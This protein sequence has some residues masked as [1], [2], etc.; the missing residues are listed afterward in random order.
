[1]G[2][3]HQQ[4]IVAHV[5]TV[6]RQ[7]F[8]VIGRWGDKGHRAAMSEVINQRICGHGPLAAAVNA[9]IRRVNPTG[10]AGTVNQAQLRATLANYIT[11]QLRPTSA[12]IQNQAAGLQLGITRPS[13]ITAQGQVTRP[14]FD[15][16]TVASYR[17]GILAA[18]RGTGIKHRQVGSAQLNLTALA[19]QTVK[20]LVVAIEVDDTA[21]NN[22]FTAGFDTVGNIQLQRAAL[23]RSG[24]GVAVHSGQ[25]HPTDTVFHQALAIPAAG[26]T[27]VRHRL[28]VQ[29][30]IDIKTSAIIQGKVTATVL[31]LPFVPR[32]AEAQGII[33]AVLA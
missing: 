28:V 33:K 14:F 21:V 19:A 11:G 24:P 23:N 2:V 4:A 25:Y 20:L 26:K 9:D 12:A 5:V 13:G 7:G 3:H 29:R 30:N 22:H 6:H 8:E 27:T 31:L 10:Q 18:I 15:Q 1:M 17:P 16:G 32:Q